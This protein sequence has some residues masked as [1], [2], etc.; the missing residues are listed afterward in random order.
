MVTSYSPTET[1]AQYR[2]RNSSPPTRYARSSRRGR[3]GGKSL[4]LPLRARQWQTV[5]AYGGPEADGN[6]LPHPQQGNSL[7]EQSEDGGHNFNPKRRLNP[8]Q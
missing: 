2:F 1:F 6:S 3:K 4:P 7:T 8:V 5:R